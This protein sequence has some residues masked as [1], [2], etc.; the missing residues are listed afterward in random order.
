MQ[1]T[2]EIRRAAGRTARML[3]ILWIGLLTGCTG[4]HVRMISPA[5]SPG[6]RYTCAPAG[7][8]KP[9]TVDVP[10]RLNPSGTKFVVLPRQCAGR[11]HQIVI[12]NAQSS[13]PEVDVTCA[14]LEEPVARPLE[15]MK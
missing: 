13:T 7:E 15:E 9:A 3:L 8:C 12:L 2:S 4:R 1:A 5:T 14:P 6:A 10:S 11:I